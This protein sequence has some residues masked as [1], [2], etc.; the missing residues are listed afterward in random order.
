M[1][2]QLEWQD[3]WLLGI[4]QFDD[5]HREMVRLINRLLDD[6]DDTP[7]QQRVSDLVVHLRMHFK[8]EEEFLRRIDYPGYCEHKHEHKMELAEVAVLLDKMNNDQN[9]V[10]DPF[11]AL[12]IKYWFLNHVVLEDKR[13][14]VFFFQERNGF[15]DEDATLPGEPPCFQFDDD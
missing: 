1:N 10:F 4:D 6:D 9:P 12:N 13:F 3:D 11:F 2:E 8:R 7:V 14:A 15:V 5:E